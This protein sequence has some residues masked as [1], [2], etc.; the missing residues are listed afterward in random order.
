MAA[1]ATA[2]P[3]TRPRSTSLEDSTLVPPAPEKEEKD[4]K[5]ETKPETTP[6]PTPN[7]QPSFKMSGNGEAKPELTGN[8]ALAPMK[9]IPKPAAP[10]QLDDG[11][12]E[13]EKDEKPEGTSSELKLEGAATGGDDG[14][15]AGDEGQAPPAA[16]AGPGGM[17]GD[18]EGKPGVKKEKGPARE[19]KDGVPNTPDSAEKEG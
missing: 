14:A 16:G 18:D 3:Q 19:K 10:T 5:T 8:P 2:E 12:E 7:E 17:G 6:A 11:K 1:L 9:A 4:I 13:K 15:G